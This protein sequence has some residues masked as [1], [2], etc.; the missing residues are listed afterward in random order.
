[1]KQ[2]IHGIFTIVL[3]LILALSLYIPVSAA[4]T[5]AA[6]AIIYGCT[7]GQKI[8]LTQYKL[9]VAELDT[10]YT[11]LWES[12]QLPWYVKE[13][14]TYYYTDSGTV[15]ELEPD[16]LPAEEFNRAVYEQ[17]LAQI[18]AACVTEDME[19]W[20]IALSLHDY[21]IVN[22]VYDESLA[23]NT[24]YE[25]MV[26]GTTVCAGYTDLYRDLLNRVG[27]PCR[28]VTSEPMEHTWNLVSLGGKW[29]HADLTWDDP[30]PNEQGFVSH[31]YFL[32]TDAEISAGEEP[33]HDWESDITCTDGRFSDAFW[34]DVE[35]AILFKDKDTAYLLRHKD[36]SNRIYRRDISSGKE[37]CI[38]KESTPYINI[39]KGQYSYIRNGLSL[40]DGRLWFCSLNK[41]YSMKPDGSGKRTEYA[42][43]AKGNG[44]YLAGCYVK[45]DTL[46]LSA[47]NHDGEMLAVTEPLKSTGYH[48]HEYTQTI[49]PPTCTQQGYTESLCD[50]G[51]RCDSDPVAPVEHNWQQL[52]GSPASFFEEGFSEEQC[53]DC[54]EIVNRHLPKM[55]FFEWLFQLIFG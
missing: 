14:Y 53:S 50:C 1:M 44:R 4:D 25:L 18:L 2:K 33:H 42:Y 46:Y 27:I 45:D 3:V 5:G 21:L 39:G 30:T 32:R 47:A 52:S 41:V 6:E 23:A 20:Q 12:G 35:S 37:T 7:Y 49:Q 22:T 29:Y 55:G 17:K 51:L 38:Y 15:T 40:W 48:I 36:F 9:T 43:N 8:D 24:G 26:K 31:K 10:L 11:E 16:L 13:S 54:G 19:D 28:S 34:K